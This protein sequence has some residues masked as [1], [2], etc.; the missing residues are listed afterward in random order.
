M[1]LSQHQHRVGNVHPAP[2]HHA[3]IDD[4]PV[5]PVPVSLT[6]LGMRSELKTMG[7]LPVVRRLIDSARRAS[8]NNAQAVM[9][10]KNAL[11]IVKRIE[12][13]FPGRPFTIT[14]AVP[15]PSQFLDSL[16][17]AS[18]YRSPREQGQVRLDMMGLRLVDQSLRAFGIQFAEGRT[19][20]QTS[21]AFPGN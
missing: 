8:R 14:A 21:A 9:L 15:G 12:A 19:S 2:I 20:H 17:N 4:A 6:Q 13:N 5:R 7:S 11:P 10:V 3:S 18:L 1:L 16:D